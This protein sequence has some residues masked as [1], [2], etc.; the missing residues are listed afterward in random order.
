MGNSQLDEK[1][2]ILSALDEWKDY[3]P[4]DRIEKIDYFFERGFSLI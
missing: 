3:V 2:L 4:S 1:Q